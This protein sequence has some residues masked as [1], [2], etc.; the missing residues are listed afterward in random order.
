[1][2]ESIIVKGKNVDDAIERGLGLLKVSKDDVEIEIIERESTSFLG[3]YVKKAVVKLTKADKGLSLVKEDTLHLN[4]STENIE[5]DFSLQQQSFESD[6]M[7]IKTNVQTNE[8]IEGKVWIKDGQLFCESSSADTPTITLGEGIQV[9]RN[10]QLVQEQT[11]IVSEQDVYEIKV[12]QKETETV[13][14][15]SIDEQQLSV[16]LHVEPGYKMNRKLIETKPAAHLELVAEESKE[17]QNDLTYEQVIQK[18]DALHVK[19]SINYSAITEAISATSPGNYEVA[20]GVKPVKG[21]NGWVEMKVNVHVQKG[22]KEDEHGKVNYRDIYSIPCIDEGNIIAVIHPPI[23]G[24]PGLTVTNVPIPAKQ[25]FPI[26]L[27]EG[28]GVNVFGNQI[29]ATE[30]GRPHI[31]QR[32]QHIQISIVPK[33]THSANVD[34]ASGNIRFRGDVEI[35]G[36]VK[37]NMTVE[38]TGD[39]LLHQTVSHASVAARGAVYSRSS[40]INSTVSAGQDNRLTRELGSLLKTM[41]QD[42]SNMMVLIDQLT[43][44][45]AFTLSDFSKKGLRPLIRL[46]LE[47]KFHHFPNLVKNYV[48]TVKEGEYYLR[49]AIW[50]DIAESLKNLFLS[51]TAEEIYLENMTELSTMIKE[52]Y[53]LSQLPVESNASIHAG[54]VMSS[55]LYCSG[56]VTVW[57]EGCTNTNIHAEGTVKIDGIVRGGE[58]YGQLGVQIHET[59]AQSGVRTTI[60]VPRDQQIQITKA[61]EGTVL[62]FGEVNYTIK[63]TKHHVLARMNENERIIFE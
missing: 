21:K 58:I 37:E 38:A 18:L 62:R 56:N 2:T 10:G 16:M 8:A 40:V 31:E 14:D 34:L 45:P 41:E 54:N 12:E 42:I 9:Y 4:D 50:H 53:E 63:E 39:I 24:L 57:G 3:I 22:P 32:K 19:S 55:T 17:I 60:S 13:W 43:E 11:I 59:G 6:D 27:R 30:T 29:V 46:L 33:L 51:V 26:E 1:M 35:I 52:C 49:D 5:T 28:E 36:E 7:L 61:M 25:T 23:P 20:A 47:K 44:S 15:V 48:E